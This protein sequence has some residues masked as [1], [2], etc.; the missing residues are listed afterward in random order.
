LGKRQ[1]RTRPVKYKV[2]LKKEAKRELKAL[3]QGEQKVIA[4]EIDKLVFDACPPSAKQL[5]GYP[6]F[7]ISAKSSR[8]IY[9]APDDNAVIRVLRIGPRSDPGIYDDL[10]GLVN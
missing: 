6:F 1:K 7:R 3:P 9:A 8:A 5:G 4:K 10:D 2:I